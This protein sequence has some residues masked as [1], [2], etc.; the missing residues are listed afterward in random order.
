MTDLPHGFPI[1]S[2]TLRA[3][4][5]VTIEQ[6]TERKDELDTLRLHAVAHLWNDPRLIELLDRFIVADMGGMK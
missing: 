2:I 3:S 5:N 1:C 4:G 6:S